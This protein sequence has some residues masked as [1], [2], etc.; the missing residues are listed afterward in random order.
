MEISI[1]LSHQRLAPDETHDTNLYAEKLAEAKLADQLGFA[2]IWVPEHHLI[3]FMQAPNGLLLASFYGAHVSCDIGQMVNLL[4]YRHPLVSAGEIA[5]TDQLLNGRLQ[6]GLGRGAY[7]YEFRRLGITWDVAEAKFLECVDVLEKVWASPDRGIA[8]DGQFFKFDKTYVWPRPAARP[9]PP[10]WYAAMTPPVIEF[11]AQ[12]G[13]NVATWPFLRPM[14]FVEEITAKFHA[15][16]ERAGGAQGKQ[17]LALMRPVFVGKT[18]EE[19]RRAA[20]TMLSNHRLSQWIRLAEAEADDRG[21]VSPRPLENEPSLEET[22]EVMIAGNPEQC[23]AKLERYEKLGVD[24]FITWFDFGME[25]AQ[26]LETMQLFAEE[27]MEPFRRSR[28]SAP[29]Q[30][31]MVG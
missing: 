8:Y 20:P 24:H 29:Q 28:A 1:F 15:A 21:Y 9:H 25:H 5:L 23:L 11:A 4:L 27:V 6:L 2:C 17:K 10:V 13:Y 16:R 30:K 31:L 3:Q 18:E 14:S 26:N 22:F 19:A 12:K 7:D